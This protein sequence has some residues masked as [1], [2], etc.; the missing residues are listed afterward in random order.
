M[1]ALAADLVVRRDHADRAVAN[2]ER[3]PQAR[4][5]GEAAVEV[6]VD[7]RGSGLDVC[8]LAATA[9]EHGAAPRPLARARARRGSRRPR[10]R[11]TAANRSC[12]VPAGRS[13]ATTRA[14]RSSRRRSATRSSSGCSS[15]SVAS[16]LPTSFSDSSRC[17]QRIASRARSRVSASSF[18]IVNPT[19]VGDGDP[20]D[21]RPPVVGRVLRRPDRNQRDHLDES[22]ADE[23][24]HELAPPAREREPEDG[25]EVQPGEARGA[26]AVA[27]AQERGQHQE[28][29]GHDELRRARDAAPAE[30][31]RDQGNAEPGGGTR[32][33]CS[34]GSAREARRG[35]TR[36]PRRAP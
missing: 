26:A 5:G 6:V 13:T 10:P 20:D 17:D 11:A 9:A 32:A 28:A 4:P 21:D 19:I 7:R 22:E 1:G 16:A 30:R 24:D 27:E 33:R 12:A 34:A 31:E 3:Y 14:P 18:R 2:D 35:R 23:A 29:E 25:E 15:V 8:P 36:P